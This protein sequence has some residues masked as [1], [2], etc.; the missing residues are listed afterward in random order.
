MVLEESNPEMIIVNMLRLLQHCRTK[1]FMKEDL[2]WTQNPTEA[3]DFSS[4]LEATEFLQKHQ[5][6]DVHLFVKFHSPEQDEITNLLGL[7]SCQA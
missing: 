3:K 6:S 7:C 4:I 1:E 2:S 5:A